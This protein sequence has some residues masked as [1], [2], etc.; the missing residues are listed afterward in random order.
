[1]NEVQSSQS[2]VDLMTSES[3]TN[4]SVKRNVPR[5][6]KKQND[7]SFANQPS[8]SRERPDS[9]RSRGDQDI[10]MQN[11]DAKNN[12]N[13]LKTAD[14]S[15]DDQNLQKDYIKQLRNNTVS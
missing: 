4:R 13:R 9:R 12:Q 14:V 1:M 15:F 5:P 7:E 10:A 6:I 11:Q 8:S 2:S 3:N